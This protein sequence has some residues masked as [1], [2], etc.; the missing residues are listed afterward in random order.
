VKF[1]VQAQDEAVSNCSKSLDGVRQGDAA[2]TGP[3]AQRSAENIRLWMSYLPS[4]CVDAMIK[5]GWDRDL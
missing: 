1:N 5:L 3:G 4:E 2:S